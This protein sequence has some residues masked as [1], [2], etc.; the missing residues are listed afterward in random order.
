VLDFEHV[1]R[2]YFSAVV[3][4]PD[5]PTL[6]PYLMWMYDYDKRLG[7]GTGSRAL[8]A[9]HR[10]IFALNANH[11][12][13]IDVAWTMLKNDPVLRDEA[14]DDDNKWN[15]LSFHLYLNGTEIKPHWDLL[16]SLSNKRISAQ[17]SMKP[18]TCIGIITLGDTRPLHFHRT[19]L[20]EELNKKNE[21][22]KLK[23]EEPGPCEIF[24]QEHGSLTIQSV[25]KDESILFR[26]IPSM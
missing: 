24:E 22:V 1:V 2:V 3:D 7:I 9:F 6:P 17:N 21:I 5:L 10:L 8:D 4:D 26:R 12:L 18:D 25:R 20:K 16:R 19:Y 11:A 13:I 15:H 23:Y 14:K